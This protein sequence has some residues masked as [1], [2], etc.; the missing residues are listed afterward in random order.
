[1][2][3]NL[4]SKLIN[5]SKASH[6]FATVYHSKLNEKITLKL[7]DFGF[8][9]HVCHG[10]SEKPYGGHSHLWVQLKYTPQLQPVLNSIK[11]V[12]KPGRRV[13]A[14]KEE[15]MTLTS[16]RVTHRLRSL[17]LGRMLP[18]QVMLINTNKLG[19]IELFE[20]VERESGGEVMCVV[21]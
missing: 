18:G 14:T 15:L 17:G 16:G 7:Y 1:M 10:N 19:V 20:A 12:S 21:H 4:F 5:A 2:R 9:Q 11:L 8:I 6:M 3:E 13:F